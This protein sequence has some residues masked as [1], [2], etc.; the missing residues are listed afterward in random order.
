MEGDQ[1]GEVG[2]N[3]GDGRLYNFFMA[4][5]IIGCFVIL[6]V[7]VVYYFEGYCSFFECIPLVPYRHVPVALMFFAIVAKWYK[8][9]WGKPPPPAAS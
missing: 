8:K 7:S 4:L 2:G 9:I 1:S 3:G 6:G 5:F